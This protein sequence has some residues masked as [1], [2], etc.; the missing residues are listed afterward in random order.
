VRRVILCACSLFAK[1][2]TRQKR[3]KVS[4]ALDSQQRTTSTHTTDEGVRCDVSQFLLERFAT[5]LPMI[6]YGPLKFIIR[7]AFSTETTC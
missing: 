6:K 3:E 5:N 4:S 2:T 7:R 1:V